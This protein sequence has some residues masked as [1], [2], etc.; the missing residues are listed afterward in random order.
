M[1]TLKKRTI[2]TEDSKGVETQIEV[3]VETKVLT[4]EIVRH[5]DSLESMIVQKQ[6][7]IENLQAEV[8]ELQAKLTQ[9]NNLSSK[10]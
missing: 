3:F 4:E 2:T 5:K 9:I 7:S 1:M 10:R 6:N 8:V